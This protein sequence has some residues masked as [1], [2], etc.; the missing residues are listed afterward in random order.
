MTEAEVLRLT[1]MSTAA[2]RKRLEE[3]L[4]ETG[5]R[6]KPAKSPSPSS[7]STVSVLTDCAGEFASLGSMLNEERKFNENKWEKK[8]EFKRQEMERKLELKKKLAVEKAKARK[9]EL[10]FRHK[11][12]IEKANERNKDGNDKKGAD[13]N[14]FQEAILAIVRGQDER[15]NK[16]E[17]LLQKIADK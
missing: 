2:S 12:L 11:L 14:G 16:M 9:E 1:A 3:V 8:L 7:M 13:S 4:E 6:T 17:Q 5:G 10:D 15:L